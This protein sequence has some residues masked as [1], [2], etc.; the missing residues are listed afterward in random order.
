[1]LRAAW[2]AFA[3]QSET[4]HMAIG[5]GR[6]G[7]HHRHG[8]GE[9]GE[10]GPDGFGR[11]FGG[12]RGGRVLGHGDLRLLLLALIGEK[13]RH[14]YDLIRA[15]EERFAGAYA[16]S[17]G[18]VYPT[19]TMLEEQDLIRAE[20]SEG[21]KRL[22]AITPE[23]QAFLKENEA[24]VEGILARVDLTASHHSSRTAPDTVWEAWKTLKQAM[25]MHRAPWTDEEADRI[26]TILAKA[27]RD[28]VGKG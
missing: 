2:R 11:G 17:P 5:R 8:H 18:A 9:D 12:R 19:L 13:P 15:V 24:Q 16:P 20:A 7:G 25:N 26:R 1:M 23:G 22:F 10:G 21:S 28:I 3:E 4:E 6:M 14:G 27:A